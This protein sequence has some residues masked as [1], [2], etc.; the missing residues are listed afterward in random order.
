MA[1]G[2]ARTGAGRPREYLKLDKETRTELERLLK[3]QRDILGQ[4]DLTEEQVVKQ[5]IHDAYTNLRTAYDEATRQAKE[6]LRQTW[7]RGQ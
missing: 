2:G 1:K 5:L 3:L 6:T 7:E 4:A